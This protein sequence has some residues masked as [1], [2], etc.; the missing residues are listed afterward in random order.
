MSD[1]I[2]IISVRKRITLV[3]IQTGV[4][5]WVTPAFPDL[6]LIIYAS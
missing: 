2:G 3:L 4:Q 1:V 5:L 6:G